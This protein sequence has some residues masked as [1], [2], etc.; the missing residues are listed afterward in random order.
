MGCIFVITT[1]MRRSSWYGLT[2]N[3]LSMGFVLL[4][5]HNASLVIGRHHRSK[6][7]LLA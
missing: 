6:H 7:G 4:F 2:S 3:V 1:S 5:P